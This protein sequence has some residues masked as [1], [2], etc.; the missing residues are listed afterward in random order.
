MEKGN[1]SWAAIVS[2]LFLSVVLNISHGEGIGR[3]AQIANVQIGVRE[4]KPA[5]RETSIVF[6][7]DIMTSRG[8]AQTI[9]K[10]KDINYPFLALRDYIKSSDIAFANLETPIIAGR[11]VVN[12]EMSFRSD[13]GI[14]KAIKDSGFSIVSLANNHSG[15]AGISGLNDTFTSLKNAG[16]MYAGAGENINKANEPVYIESNGTKIAI[17]AYTDS[18]FTPWEYEA[19][20]YSPGVAFMK[21]EK[22]IESVKIAKSKSDFVIVSMHAG[23][24]YKNNPNKLQINFAHAAIDAGADLVIGHHPH[25]VQTLEKYKGKYIFY[26]LGNFI[27]DQMFS[28]ATR[29]GLVIK[30]NLTNDVISAIELTPT[31]MERIAQPRIADREKYHLVLDRLNYNVAED[32][33]FTVF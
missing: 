25:V 18:T 19:R 22:M 1:P 7:G 16:I 28:D 30:V 8:V 32:K 10:N 2:L 33:V 29:E 5:E 4:D 23:D 20:K 21:K 27:F 15:N 24:E 26:S 9:K 14:E 11:E 13:P 12:F 3:E 31:W 17:V 6:V